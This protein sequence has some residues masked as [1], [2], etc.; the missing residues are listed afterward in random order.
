MMTRAGLVVIA[1]AL[2]ACSP[3]QP[4]TKTAEIPVTPSAPQAGCSAVASRDWSA[5]GSQYYVIEAEAQG[6]TC[7][8]AV[9]TIRIRARE[10][11]VLFTRDYPVA[12]VPLAFNPNNDQ[13]GLRTDLE[14]WIQN[15]AE[16]PTADTL[17]A[18]PNGAGNP[19]GFTPAAP[20]NRYEGA[21]GAQ[22]PLFC[23]PDG[24]ESNACVAMAGDSATLLGSLTPGR[25]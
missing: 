13:T 14:A 17:P 25:P 16:P 9:A 20:R 5:V 11:E 19:P 12:Q 23:Y 15:T 8:A 22:G 24:A 7:A 10:G 21:R 6:E 4:E 18:W 2:A 3:P 1:F